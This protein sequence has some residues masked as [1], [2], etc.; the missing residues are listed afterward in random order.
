MV[1]QLIRIQLLL[2]LRIKWMMMIA[3]EILI[4]EQVRSKQVKAASVT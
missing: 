4:F 1:D 2:K 3:T